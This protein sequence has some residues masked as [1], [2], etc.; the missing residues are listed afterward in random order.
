M[1][2]GKFEEAEKINKNIKGIEK[3]MYDINKIVLPYRSHGDIPKLTLEINDEAIVIE[4][5]T[6][7]KDILDGVLSKMKTQLEDLK[8]EFKAL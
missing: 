3:A 2:W 1:E 5:T 6:G 4:S 8:E 7:K